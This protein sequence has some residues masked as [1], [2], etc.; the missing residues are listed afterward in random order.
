MSWKKN[1]EANEHE[2]IQKKQSFLSKIKFLE[3]FK[4]PYSITFFLIR[5]GEILWFS[6]EGAFLRPLLKKIIGSEALRPYFDP[7]WT[8]HSK[9]NNFLVE[10]RYIKNRWLLFRLWKKY[11][12]KVWFDFIIEKRLSKEILYA[13]FCRYSFNWYPRLMSRKPIDKNLIQ[14]IFLRYIVRFGKQKNCAH[15]VPKFDL[16]N[17]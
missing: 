2:Q 15:K 14:K 7:K 12:L 16:K 9:L 10:K 5:S 11:I 6:M 13:Y 17:L 3:T 1:N 4:T 8:I